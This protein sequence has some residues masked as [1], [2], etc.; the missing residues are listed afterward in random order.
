MRR[1]AQKAT[2]TKDAKPITLQSIAQRMMAEASGDIEAAA[3]KIFNYCGNYP[4]LAEELGM[5]AARTLAHGVPI[6]AR[7]QAQAARVA[8]SPHKFTPAILA[9]QRRAMRMGQSNSNALLNDPYTIGGQT[10]PLRDW[11]GDTIRDHGE[12]QLSRGKAQVRNGQF[13]ILV[14]TAAGHD[15]IG[16]KLDEAAVAQMRAE[17]DA[18]D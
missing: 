6:A 4:R 18:L 13:L 5:H 8:P 16:Q 1:A 15:V 11:D 14:G 17:A 9:A 7:Q 10:K 2:A 3:R 12:Q